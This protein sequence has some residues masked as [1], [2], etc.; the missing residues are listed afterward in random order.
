MQSNQ[1]DQA[2]AALQKALVLEKDNSTAILMLARI[3]II[4]GSVDKA[5]ANYETMIQKNPKD[6]RPVMLLGLVQESQGNWQK[7]QA[8]Y[9]KALQVIPDYPLAANNLAYIMLEHGG[10]PDVA[11]GYAQVAR[12]G[13]PNSPASADTLAWAYYQKGSFRLAVDLLEEALKIEPG[14][15]NIQYHLGLAYQG[16]ND[17]VHAREH[18]QRALQIN[19]NYPKAKEIHKALASLGAK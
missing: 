8:L 17:N 2:E 1:G 9:E 18:L 4:R 3:Q 19:P 11:L 16:T 7:A 5:V 6:V 13:M 10:N 15:A 12:R 14:D